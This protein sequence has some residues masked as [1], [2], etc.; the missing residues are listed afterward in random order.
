MTE[1]RTIKAKIVTEYNE[2]KKC[3]D[4][5]E[6]VFYVMGEV[7]EEVLKEVKLDKRAGRELKTIGVAGAGIA[8]ATLPITAPFTIAVASAGGLAYLIGKFGG[9]IRKYK[10]TNNQMKNRIEFVRIKGKDH[11]NKGYDNIID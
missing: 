2:V 6:L 4:N 8:I 10:I 5:N 3:I 1:K 9:N 11:F 7:Q